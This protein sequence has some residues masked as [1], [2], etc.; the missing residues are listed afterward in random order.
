MG[1]ESASGGPWCEYQWMLGRGGI[2]RLLSQLADPFP[3]TIVLAEAAA[4]LHSSPCVPSVLSQQP[5]LLSWRHAVE[6]IRP[7]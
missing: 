7:V 5:I 6:E 3:E 4:L 1:L 2:V